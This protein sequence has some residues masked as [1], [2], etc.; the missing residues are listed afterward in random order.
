MN[1]KIC[2]RCS[3][4]FLTFYSCTKRKS[5][6]ISPTSKGYVLTKSDSICLSRTKISYDSTIKPIIKANCYSCHIVDEV[7][8]SNFSNLHK[9]ATNGKLLGDI[10]H[11][12]GYKAM[13]VYDPKLDTCSIYLIKTWIDEGALE[14]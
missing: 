9:Y 13:P 6:S 1:I 3:L 2:V 7:D 10:E 12:R 11:K 4:I 5:E 14:N 8:L